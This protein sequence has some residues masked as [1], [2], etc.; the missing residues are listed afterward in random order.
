MDLQVFRNH[1]NDL[2]PAQIQNS[3]G[4]APATIPAGRLPRGDE[5]RDIPPMHRQSIGIRLEYG[6]KTQFH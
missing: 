6:H 3:L 1:G 4:F 2:T 5:L